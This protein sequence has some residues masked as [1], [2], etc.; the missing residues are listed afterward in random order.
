MEL[1]DLFALKEEVAAALQVA[2]PDHLQRVSVDHQDSPN[3]IFFFEVDGAYFAQ[4]SFWANN[5]Y[6]I[7]A[8]NT[9]EGLEVMCES[10][11]VTAIQDA[12]SIVKRFC[13]IAVASRGS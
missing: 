12:V 6:R 2:F 5:E 3:P 11:T 13:E 7:E 4:G 9:V 8:M 1:P 10:G